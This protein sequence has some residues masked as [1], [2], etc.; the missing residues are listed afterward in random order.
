PPPRQART[1]PHAI[2]TP[3]GSMQKQTLPYKPPIQPPQRLNQKTQT[4]N[5]RSSI[6][7]KAF[8]TVQHSINDTNHSLIA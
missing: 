8:H 3:P 7:T 5:S 2:T 4:T 6:Y 1:A